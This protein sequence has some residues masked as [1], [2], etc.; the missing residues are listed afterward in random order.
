M[1]LSQYPGFWP[2]A[3]KLLEGWK[4]F[5]LPL[6]DLSVLKFGEDSARGQSAAADA[7]AA[8]PVF[9]R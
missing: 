8:G 9:H 5:P 3:G 2:H 4:V 1:L 7:K 6:T